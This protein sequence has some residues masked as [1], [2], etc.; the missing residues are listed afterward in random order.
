MSDYSVTN[1]NP[2]NVNDTLYAYQSNRTVATDPIQQVPKTN[3]ASSVS[4]ETP[5]DT[6]ELSAES[7]IRKNKEKGMSTG[8]KWLLGIGVTAAAVYG[9]VVGHRALTKP[10]I[11]KVAKNFSE[12]F[13]RDVSKE[14]A[15]KL[16]SN[17]KEIFKIDNPD[18]F[19]NKLFKQ[20]KKDYGYEKL[21]IPLEINYLTDSSLRAAL[22]RLELGSWSAAEGVLRLNLGV[23]KNKPL[24]S[25][26]KEELMN[27][28]MHEFQH[29]KQTEIAYRTSAEKLL[30]AMQ[31]CREKLDMKEYIENILKDK[32]ELRNIARKENRTV[33]EVT[34]EFQHLL[35]IC[36]KNKDELLK[37][38]KDS[39]DKEKTNTVLKKLFGNMPKLEKESKE[40]E[41]GMKYIDNKANYVQPTVNDSKYREQIIEKEAFGVEDKFDQIY[42]SF[43]NIWR[44]PFFQ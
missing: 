8:L 37:V 43:A 40:Y 35:E 27:T 23:T 26:L 17:Y 41:L 3:Y 1:Y 6:F 16:V 2:N 28:L 30:D 11:E 22:D 39:F 38:Q 25:H 5:P 19:C 10:S 13:R 4:L 31:K 33:E 12:I 7:K 9:A 44:I 32:S 24:T 14:E 20:V 18:E 36:E 21:D 15:Q 29:A 34:K 42:N